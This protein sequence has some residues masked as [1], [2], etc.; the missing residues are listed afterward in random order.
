MRSVFSGW[1][2]GGWRS[3]SD[4]FGWVG[5]EPD[6]GKYLR[7]E[8]IRQADERGLGQERLALKPRAEMFLQ[9][10]GTFG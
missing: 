8:R 9:R 4:G 7:G 10:R 3:A 2:C 6:V 5:R 1:L